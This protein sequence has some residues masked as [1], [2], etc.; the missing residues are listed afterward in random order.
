[1]LPMIETSP[2]D[3]HPVLMRLNVNENTLEY[4]I[5]RRCE[6]FDDLFKNKTFHLGAIS[7]E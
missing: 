7:K 5:E 4:E 2:N 3:T 1:M 6:G